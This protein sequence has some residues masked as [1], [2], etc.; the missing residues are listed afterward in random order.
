MNPVAIVTGAA[1]GI[2]RA[3]ALRL[4]ADGYIPLA[5]DMQP[6]TPSRDIHAIRLDI[7]ATEAPEAICSAAEALGPVAALVNNAGIGGA[8]AVAESD[9]PGWQR[10]LDV[11]LTAAMRISRAVLPGMIARGQGAIVH[12]ASVFGQVGYRNNA[13][14]AASKAGIEGLTRQMA[15][16][17]GRRGIRTNAVAP[18]LIETAMTAR[19]LHDPDYRRIMQDGTPTPGPGQPEDVAGAVSFLLSADARFVNGT[20]L[21]VDGGWQATR[22]NWPMDSKD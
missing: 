3:I 13:A 12:L 2:G 7:A 20:V 21:N 22:I 17:Y 14:Y 19:F 8:R 9:D 18:G 1:D 15:A 11:N 10:I 6:F 4:A 16:D 5:V